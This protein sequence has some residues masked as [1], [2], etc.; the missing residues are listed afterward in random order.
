MKA[1]IIGGAMRGT[2]FAIVSILLGVAAPLAAQSA[3]PSSREGFHV[4]VGAAISS[5][6]GA[7]SPAFLVP[8]DLASHLRLEPE[9]GFSRT[10]F[11]ENLQLDPRILAYDPFVTAHSEYTS[12]ATNIGTGVFFVDVRAKVKLQGGARVGYAR[13]SFTTTGTIDDVTRLSG[14]FVG[15]AFGGEFFL[16][17]RF[18]LGAE[19]ELR[20]TSLD[21]T[22]ETGTFVTILSGGTV[23]GGTV[24]AP[25][26]VRQVI[27]QRASTSQTFLQT[28]ASVVA[29]V[30]LK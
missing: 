13:T 19:V 5:A 6:P 14:F 15:P 21:G 9:I 22:Q 10:T 4:G 27:T 11:A 28:R 3:S 12:T 25:V 20:Y 7:A 30:Y 18:S 23:I 24:V 8:I 2:R 1:D 26:P 17:D 16:S 29:R